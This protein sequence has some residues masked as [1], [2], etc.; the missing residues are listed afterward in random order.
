MTNWTPDLTAH[1]G[2]RYQAIAAAIQ[3]DIAEGR[4][5]P[6]T[7]LP[8]HRELAWR[9]GVTVGTV[10]R[11]YAAAE[12]RGLIRGEI[13]RGTFVRGGPEAE[14]L[15]FS[16]GRQGEHRI[17]LGHAGPPPAAEDR[18]LLGAFRELAGAGDFGA[19]FGYQPNFGAGAVRQAAA[20]WLARR[21]LNVSAS[22]IA[23]T[24]GGQHAMLVALAC[25]AQPGERILVEEIT[26][27][28]LHTTARF[29]GQRMEPV[30]IDDEGMTPEALD[31]ACRSKGAKAVYL[32]P[33]LHNPTTATMSTE[34]RQAMIDVCRRHDLLIIEDD[35]FGYLEETPPALAA[36]APDRT[37]YLTSL[38]KS[39]APGLRVGYLVLP[40]AC[41]SAALRAM[42]ASC[43]MA[44]PAMARLAAHL[45]E[46]GGA[47]RVLAGHRREALER[48]KICLD[49][50]GRWDPRCPPGALIA[51]LALPEP[52]RSADFAAEAERRGVLVSPCERFTLA[53]ETPV[54][55]VRVCLGPPA[56]REEL[57]QGLATLA[58]ML[59]EPGLA[60]GQAVV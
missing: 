35:V 4:L 41:R 50:L 57:S 22:Q 1:K 60:A 48:R 36:L 40:P 49:L 27:S 3:D 46:S 16:D 56:D 39:L 9:L 12:R 5:K 55:G 58:A 54:H 51:W 19:V 45:I 38:S 59:D 31:Q 21:G 42:Q 24:A 33:S 43:I 18:L 25:A 37:L 34:R 20:A 32:I 15:P 11:G 28:G 53:R 8:T 2:S 14:P 13:G 6:G 10:T 7:K 17:D 29:L 47:D 44:A 23:V 52:W 30:T 26:Y